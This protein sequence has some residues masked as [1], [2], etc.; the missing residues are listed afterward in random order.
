MTNIQSYGELLTA[1]E[2]DLTLTYRL[3]PYGEEGHTNLGSITA[4][5]GVL[6]LPTDFKSS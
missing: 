1:S 6:Q 2:D 5:K 4:S 3:L